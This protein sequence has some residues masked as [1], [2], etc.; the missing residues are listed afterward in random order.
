MR[1]SKFI[2]L[3]QDVLLEWIYDS[4]N[5]LQEDYRIIIDTLKDT[6]AFSNTETT[7]TVLS[8]TDNTSKKQLFSLDTQ[9]RK[10]GIVDPNTDTN[11][12]LFLQFKNFSGNVPFRYDI[13]RLHFPV[14]YTFKDKLGFLF[15]ISL[16]NDLQDIKFPL[17]NFY[18]DKTDFNRLD[19]ELTSPPFMFNEKLWGKFIEIKI[20][21]PFALVNDVSIVQGVRIPRAGTIHK[22]LV[23]EDFNVLSKE[24]PIF[25]SFQFL[26]KKLNTLNQ[27]SFLTTEPFSA[28][29]PVIPEFEQLGIQIIPSLQGDYFEIFGTFN[30]TISE[31]S[32]F[33]Q[34]NN[35]QGKSY[36]VIYEITV[37]EKN[38]ISGNSTQ[39]QF[40][41]F[42]LP[43]EFRPIIKFSTTT[44][45]I[46][47][48]MKII[49][50]VDDSTITRTTTY[51]MLQNEVAKYSRFLTK[52]DIK[53]TFKP[54]VYNA[55]PDLI[56]VQLGTGLRQVEKV[57]VPMPIM[58]ER[59]NIS[60]KN[61][62]EQVNS[63]IYYGQGQQQILLFP[64]NNI[65]KF[66][67]ISSVDNNGAKAF[68]I[69]AQSSI[70]LRFKSNDTLVEFPLFYDSGEVDLS[71]GIVV[72]NVLETQYDTLKKMYQNGFDQFYIAMKTD[73]GITTILF[74]GRFL[75][76]DKF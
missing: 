24:T 54:K 50:A 2:K 1:I 39:T 5:F 60:V 15:N 76:S 65:F 64:S 69:P 37:F 28:T 4:D 10:W 75:P 49:N 12:Y 68:E 53:N 20:P 23:D 30:N 6:R 74:F 56:N 16:M 40:E 48:T 22:N 33:I 45:V 38:I 41:N 29:I 18:Y 26:T 32:N 27:I 17:S 46:D 73:S 21:S 59:I 70:F 7:N 13:V 19:L 57:N 58:F 43:I 62:S 72:F 51:A 44:A 66:S 42:D 52:I 71:R 8:E 11:K 35:L 47:V 55:K 14:N 9:T 25:L 36:Y 34:M 67:I 63:T 31:F 61:V 3:D